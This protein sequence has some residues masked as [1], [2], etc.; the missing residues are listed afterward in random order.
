VA[1]SAH[2]YWASILVLVAATGCRSAARPSVAP[3]L[4]LRGDPETGIAAPRIRVAVEISVT[5]ASIA[6]ESGVHVLPM[7]GHRGRHLARATF[8]ATDAAAATMLYTVQVASLRD[9]RIA[10]AAARR[11][12]SAAATPAT[13]EWS[14]AAGAYRVRVGRLATRAA[15]ESLAQRLA[16][17]AFPG[18][19]VAELPGPATGR[20]RL[21]E[22]AAQVGAVWVLP[23]LPSELLFVDGRAYRGVLQVRADPRGGVTVV[24]LLHLEDYLRGVV[25]NELSPNA[26]PELEAL[27]A[28]AVAARTYAVRHLGDSSGYGYDLCATPACQVYS[29]QGTEHDLSDRAVDETRGL[30]AYHAGRPIDALYTSTCGGHTEHGWNIFRGTRESAPYLEGTVCGPEREEW[31]TLT[32]RIE[33]GGDRDTALLKN[34]GVLGQATGRA[35]L[36]EPLAGRELTEWLARISAILGRD[37]DALREAPTR[38]GAFFVA[39]IQ[40]LCWEDRLRLLAPRDVEYALTALDSEHWRSDEER[41]AAALLLEERVLRP[42]P[43]GALLPQRTLTS[44]EAIEVLARAIIVARPS[45]LRS[46]RFR[47]MDGDRVIVA[48]GE[49]REESLPLSLDLALFRAAAE[50]SWPAAHLSVAP[51]ASLRYVVVAG[52]VAY[53]EVLQVHQGQA[54]D[55]SSRYYKWEERAT[56]EE[57]AA[58]AV[59]LGWRGRLTDVIVKRRGVSGRVIE[60]ALTGPAGELVLEGLDVRRALGLREN[61]FAIERDRAADGHVRQFVFAGRGWGHGVGLCQVGAFGM[62]QAGARFDEILRHYYRAIEVRAFSPH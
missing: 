31:G 49:G 12:E 42:F 32:G 38:R 47:R 61:L 62:A 35:R 58:R 46:G 26:F 60:A 40:A 27:K 43:D 51:G 50:G 28:Q 59:P 21:L 7:D 56:P 3:D 16:G 45:A 57:L 39:L 52:R 36:T 41:Q 6:A 8:L 19:W 55:R 54:W 18:A 4:S 14:D 24:N 33:V 34:L 17:G 48:H 5:R 44:A 1:R 13:V 30:V 23:V 10:R 15:A 29:G 9:D 25:P 22:D 53:L 11:A 2:A 37:C 20:M